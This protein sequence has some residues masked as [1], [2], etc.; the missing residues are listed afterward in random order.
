MSVMG[1]EF[2]PFYFGEDIPKD[3]FKE[4]HRIIP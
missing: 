4:Y 3:L 2:R 1:K